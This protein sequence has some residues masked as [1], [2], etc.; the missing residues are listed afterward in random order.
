MELVNTSADDF[1]TDLTNLEICLNAKKKHVNTIYSCD[2][3]YKKLKV[4]VTGDMVDSSAS[5]LSLKDIGITSIKPVISWGSDVGS[6]AS[7]ISGL[8]DVENIKNMIAKETNYTKS[9]NSIND[10]NID[11][12]TSKKTHI[13]MYVLGHPPK[14]LLYS[15]ISDNNEVLELSFSKFTGIIKSSFISDLS[16]KKT[17]KLAVSEKILVNNNVK[18]INK[19][20]DWEIVIKEIPVNLPKLA[21]ESVFSKFANLV[22]V[23]WSVFIKKDS[24]Y[25]AKAIIGF[26]AHDFSNL[27]ASYNGKTCA[28]GCNL[29]TYVCNRC[30]VICFNDKTSRVAAIS[31]VS[32]FKVGENSG[33]CD[34]LKHSVELLADQVSGI[35]KKLSFIKLVPLMFS[36]YASFLVTSVLLVSDFN[37][38]MVLD[39]TLASSVPFFPVVVNV[40]AD[41]SLSSFKILTTKMEEILGW[42][43]LVWLLFKGKLL[44]TV[45]GLYAGVLS[46]VKFELASKVWEEYHVKDEA[47]SSVMCPINMSDLL[48]VVNGLPKGKAIELS[49]ILNKLWKHGNDGVLV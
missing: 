1:R 28:I 38:N 2:A 17:K 35:L 49:D 7:S 23:K 6:I 39:G 30:T 16:L 47:F 43:I 46:D 41:F 18:Q 44:V 32:V 20:S 8:L 42:V 34:S 27:L 9:D 40:A 10:E 36:S 45:L 31:S 13:Y 11:K 29:I 3:F 4:P 19:Y 15:D 26:T 14:A 12:T 24:V 37:L 33:V 22:A 5:F 48:L 21:V 25:M